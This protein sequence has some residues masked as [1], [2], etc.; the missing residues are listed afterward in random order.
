MT[1]KQKLKINA[2]PTFRAPATLR[3]AGDGDGQVI[4]V[5]FHAVFRRVNDAQAKEMQKQLEAG[6]LSD[7][8]LLDQVL[9]GWDGLEAEDGAPFA[10]SPEN[11]ASAQYDWPTFE[12]SLVASYFKNSDVALAKN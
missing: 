5:N 4:E 12:A 11:R 10:Y 9:A 2:K 8:A 6:Q 3:L 1:Q 7:G